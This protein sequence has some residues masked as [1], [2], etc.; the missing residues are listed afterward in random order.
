M[1]WEEEV[2]YKVRTAATTPILE[3]NV[4]TTGAPREFRIFVYP[5]NASTF[6]SYLVRF[7]VPEEIACGFM[8]GVDNM[9]DYQVQQAL[10]DLHKQSG[11][12]F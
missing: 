9:V 2:I 4:Q 7:T 11:W 12:S 5:V 10:F 6:R 1:S 8:N 3:F